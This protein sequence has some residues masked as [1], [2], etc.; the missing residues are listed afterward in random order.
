MEFMKYLKC[1][2]ISSHC[3][4]TEFSFF[5][6]FVVQWLSYSHIGFSFNRLMSPNEHE[7]QEIWV[8]TNTNISKSQIFDGSSDDNRPDAKKKKKKTT[9]RHTQNRKQDESMRKLLINSRRFS[10]ENFYVIVMCICRL[11]KFLQRCCCCLLNKL[12][13]NRHINGAQP[14]HNCYYEWVLIKFFVF[15]MTD[16]FQALLITLI[17]NHTEHQNWYRYFSIFH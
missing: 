1:L 4:R 14:I 7:F 17:E 3:R 16:S 11:Q 8:R 12:Y 9:F 13:N 15:G 2:M 10:F 6:C 5:L